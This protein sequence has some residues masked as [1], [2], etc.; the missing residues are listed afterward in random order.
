[1]RWRERHL[2]VAVIAVL[3]VASVISIRT[4]S[5]IDEESRRSSSFD[6]YFRDL[7]MKERKVTTTWCYYISEGVKAEHS[8]TTTQNE[9][10]T[11]DEWVDRHD[12][13]VTAAKVKYPP[14]SCD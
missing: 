4:C 10:E 11:I 6:I 8:V 12:A 13:I 1:M 14:V 9:G 2:N 5:R 7:D 3:F